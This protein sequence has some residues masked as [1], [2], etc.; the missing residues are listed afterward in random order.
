MHIWFHGRDVGIATPTDGGL[1]LYVAFPGLE[2][3]DEFKRDIEGELR[4]LVGSLPDAPPIAESRLAGPLVGKLDL[5]TEWR[6]PAGRA[7]ALAGDAAI[8]ADPVGAIG[9]GWALQSAEWLADA[10]SPA[11]HGERRLAA[12]LRAYRR[13]H[14]RELL[15]HSLMAADGARAKPPAPPQRLLFAAA[16][17]DP[18][19][20]RRV[21][22]FAAREIR[23]HQLLAPRVLARA[24]LVTAR[25][26]PRAPR[27]AARTAAP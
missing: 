11:L 2:R 15:G 21:G 10:V 3:V 9:C 6:R 14:R 27:G 13:R 23:P 12:A 7:L 8:A 19:T 17:H 5:T 16:V 26:R 22:A 25:R 20:A 1:M 18:V 24:A 4:G